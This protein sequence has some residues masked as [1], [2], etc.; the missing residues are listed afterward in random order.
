[1]SRNSTTSRTA[2]RRRFARRAAIA[3]AA[4]A[5]GIGAVAV[6]SPA[7]AAPAPCSSGGSQCSQFSGQIVVS[8]SLTLQPS[9]GTWGTATFSPDGVQHTV[10]TFVL[11][12]DSTDSAGSNLT[13]GIPNALTAL[14]DHEFATDTFTPTGTKG[15][16]PFTDDGNPVNVYDITTPTGNA[17]GNDCLNSV[18]GFTGLCSVRAQASQLN[19][20]TLPHDSDVLGLG[21]YL[22]VP[23]GTAGS[24]A[25]GYSQAFNYNLTGA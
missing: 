24:P 16:A 15:Q 8:S 19:G 2:S 9:T 25:A 5:T 7:S 18:D 13:V 23:T 3:T 17:P 4:A 22:T 10:G 6:A 21:V 12:V 14:P 11:D 1:M 20:T